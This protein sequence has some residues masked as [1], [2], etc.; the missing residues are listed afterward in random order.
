ML[1]LRWCS[2]DSEMRRFLIGDNF[3]RLSVL[4]LDEMAELVLIPLGNVSRSAI[5]C[6]QRAY[7]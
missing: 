6:A 3:G 5:V 7:V 4:A 2:A 1:C